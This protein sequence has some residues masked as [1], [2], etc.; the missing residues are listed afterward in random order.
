MRI[1]PYGVRQIVLSHAGLQ[2]PWDSHHLHLIRVQPH[3]A[4]ICHH[5]S[6]ANYWFHAS[7]FVGQQQ[8]HHQHR[9]CS[10]LK[11]LKASLWQ[12]RLWRSQLLPFHTYNTE[13]QKTHEKF[14]QLIV[15]ADKFIIKRDWGL[16]K[17]FNSQRKRTRWNIMTDELGIST[18]QSMYM[19]IH[20]SLILPLSPSNY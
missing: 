19:T 5:L 2:H 11:I 14:P 17:I 10:N 18:S 7:S 3:H 6:S 12:P 16:G 1:L 8:D 13:V 4:P 15:T 9:L 20:Q